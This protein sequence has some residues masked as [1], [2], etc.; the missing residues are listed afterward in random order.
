MNNKTIKQAIEM[1]DGLM[2]EDTTA[3]DL[4]SGEYERGDDEFKEGWNDALTQAKTELLKLNKQTQ[5]GER[6]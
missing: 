6:W 3:R 4:R 5:E 2:K 1:I